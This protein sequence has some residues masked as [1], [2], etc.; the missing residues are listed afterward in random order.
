MYVAGSKR[1]ARGRIRWVEDRVVSGLVAEIPINNVLIGERTRE[2]VEDLPPPVEAQPVILDV[3]QKREIERAG[4]DGAGFRVQTLAGLE[5]LQ[6]V[7]S[8]AS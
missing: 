1:T 8:G 2:R 6:L 5:A 4:A 7:R 3:I